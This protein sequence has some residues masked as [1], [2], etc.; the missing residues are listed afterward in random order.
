MIDLDGL[1]YFHSGSDNIIGEAKLDPR[2][3]DWLFL[4]ETL[5][6]LSLVHLRCFSLLLEIF[7]Y[8]I[9]SFSMHYIKHVIGS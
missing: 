3:R 6:F 9:F 5:I 4:T 8:V 1:C 7:L 2:Q